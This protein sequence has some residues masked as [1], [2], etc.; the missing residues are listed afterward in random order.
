MAA[1]G[2]LQTTPKL[3]SMSMRILLVCTLFGSSG[4]S[5]LI[6]RRNKGA[7]FKGRHSAITSATC[8]CDGRNET[9]AFNEGGGEGGAAITLATCECNN[10]GRNEVA[11]N[12]GHD[13]G[14]AAI[15]V[16][17]WFLLGW[18]VY[19]TSFEHSVALVARL[20]T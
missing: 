15:K 14:G 11:F 3:R 2:V 1:I 17:G 7:S 16:D 19:G 12:E 6:L 5:S 9:V 18:F 4:F 10:D 20:K 8:E 13:G